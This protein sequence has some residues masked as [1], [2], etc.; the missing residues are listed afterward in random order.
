VTGNRSRAR[1]VGAFGFLGAAV[2]PWVLW[3]RVVADIA[4]EFRVDVHYLLLELTPWA[5]ILAGL[6]FLVPVALSAGADPESRWYPRGR[7]AYAG[8]GV[9][10]YLLGVGL[11]SQVV[12]LWSVSTGVH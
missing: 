5:L 11:A 4:S 3:W 8:W 9:T 10:L 2:A 6:L 7:N 12:Q 1:L